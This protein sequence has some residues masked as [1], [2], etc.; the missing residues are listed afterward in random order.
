VGCYWYGKTETVLNLASR[1]L[2]FADV[3]LADPDEQFPNDQSQFTWN[4]LD[5][6]GYAA[7]LALNKYT[8]PEG[9]EQRFLDAPCNAMNICAFATVL[10]RDSFSPYVTNT[11][12][13]QWF[14]RGFYDGYDGI[15]SLKG[16]EFMTFIATKATLRDKKKDGLLTAA[17]AGLRHLCGRSAAPLS[18]NEVIDMN[19]ND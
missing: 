17:S 9:V 8:L 7:E 10:G 16:G 15:P 6:C 19:E 5:L 1:S 3:I 4:R 2:Q 11:F 14:F 12:S 18:P 13:K